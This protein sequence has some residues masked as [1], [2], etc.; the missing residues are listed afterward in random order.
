MGRRWSSQ[1]HPHAVSHYFP[2]EISN[3]DFS[4][5]TSIIRSHAVV[6]RR[7]AGIPARRDGPVVQPILVRL[8]L[9]WKRWTFETHVSFNRHVVRIS[10]EH[11]EEEEEKG[12]KY[13]CVERRS[14]AFERAVRMPCA[15][16]EEKVNAEYHDGV[17]TV[18]LTKSEEAK[19]HRIPVKG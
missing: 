5:N 8:G 3:D 13:H 19:T 17:L 4:L 6:Q 1:Q 18:T 12:R 9:G 2:R 15:V 16:N 7:S 14:G 11:K 10:G